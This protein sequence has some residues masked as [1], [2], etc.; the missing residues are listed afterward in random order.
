MTA[1]ANI[2]NVQNAFKVGI[3]YGC[4]ILSKTIDKFKKI[5]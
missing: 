5:L 1:C 3:E 4:V 2:P